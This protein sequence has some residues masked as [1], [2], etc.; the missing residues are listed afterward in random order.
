MSETPPSEPSKFKINLNPDQLRRLLRSQDRE[1]HGLY[2][3]V[4][5]HARD[6]QDA[7][8]L[9]E[10]DIESMQ[11][12]QGRLGMY[13]SPDDWVQA[14]PMKLDIEGQQFGLFAKHTACHDYGSLDSAEAWQNLLMAIAGDSSLNKSIGSGTTWI[15]TIPEEWHE[16][17][18]KAIKISAQSDDLAAELFRRPK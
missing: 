3:E 1:G 15:N 14:A 7:L 18:L 4:A 8:G 16:K 11:N 17:I 5:R 10:K 12:L 13:P 2:A 9:N 6:Y